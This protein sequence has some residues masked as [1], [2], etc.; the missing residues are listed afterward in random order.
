MAIEETVVSTWNKIKE[1]VSFLKQI[2]QS[3]LKE[4]FPPK[5]KVKEPAWGECSG[6]TWGDWNINNR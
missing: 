4:A 5:E 6:R 3:N 2:T 1:E